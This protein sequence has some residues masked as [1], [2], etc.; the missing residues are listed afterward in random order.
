[1]M[2]KM[3]FLLKFVLYLLLLAL[4]VGGGA[5]LWAGRMDGPAME[6]D[7]RAHSSDRPVTLD[8]TVR[9]P[10][11]AAA[12][13]TVALEQGGKSYSVFA[14]EP[15]DAQPSSANRDAADRLLVMRPIGKRADSR[16]QSPAPARLVVARRRDP[17][18]YRHPR[19]GVDGH[20]RSAGTARAAACHRAVHVSLRQSWRQRIRRLPGDARRRAVRRPRRR[21]GIPGSRHPASESPAIQRCAS[22]SLRCCTTSRRHPYR[23]V[24][25]RRGREPGHRRRSTTRVS[26]GLSKAAASRS[27]IAFSSGSSR[28]LHRSSAGRAD[29]DTDDVLAGFSRSTGIC[30]RRTISTI[31]RPGEEEPPEMLFMDAFQQ[32]GNSAVRGAIRRQPDLRLQREGNR[33]AGAP[34]VRS[35]RRRPTCP[36]PP[37]ARHRRPCRRPRHLRQL[38]HP[39]PRS[40]RAVALRAPVLHW[41]QGGRQ[42]R[43]GPGNRPQRTDR[44]GGRRSSALHDARGR[45]TGHAVDW[46]SAQWMQ[47]R[48]L[49]KIAA[50][51]RTP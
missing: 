36:S 2:R 46:W 6:S 50:I 21:Q 12:T 1:M 5:W 47:D 49:R 11:A 14:T 28:R 26:Q 10:N 23:C 24:R 51:R 44:P 25:P 39:R 7:N 3:R 17:V 13:V 42:S 8:M 16:A 22:R 18:L 48:V 41:R 30:A 27:T 20:T 45:P 37:P 40:G 33:P 35:R 29:S 19:G 43:E 32:L 4:V 38:R 34:R 9:A 15:G 31:A